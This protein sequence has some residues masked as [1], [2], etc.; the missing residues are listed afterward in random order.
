MKGCEPLQFARVFRHTMYEQAVEPTAS[1]IDEIAEEARV[2]DDDTVLQRVVAI[3]TIISTFKAAC[4]RTQGT[5]R[6]VELRNIGGEDMSL[7]IEDVGGTE[8]LAQRRP[9]IEAIRSVAAQVGGR[10]EVRSL[11]SGGSRLVVKFAPV[12][13]HARRV[14]STWE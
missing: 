12:K 9:A 13:R 10:C 8:G 4:P 7:I 14:R 11:R 2:V 1:S 5:R 6:R 3:D